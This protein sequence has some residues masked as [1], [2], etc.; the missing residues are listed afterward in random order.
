MSA[1]STRPRLSGYLRRFCEV[2]LPPNEDAEN[3]PEELTRKAEFVKGKEKAL[4]SLHAVK[5]LIVSKSFE[6]EDYVKNLFHELGI[7]AKTIVGSESSTEVIDETSVFLLRLFSKC[8]IIGT[9]QNQKLREAFGTFPYSSAREAFTVVKKIIES[10]NDDV[11]DEIIDN[12]FEKKDD[13]LLNREFGADIKFCDIKPLELQELNLIPFG[14]YSENVGKPLKNL[15]FKFE[16]KE[17]KLDVPKVE[18]MKYDQQWLETQI[19]KSSSNSSSSAASPSDL[20]ETI[21]M[22]LQSPSTNEELQ[23][24]LFDLLGFDRYEFIQDILRHRSDLLSSKAAVYSE[25]KLNKPLPSETRPGFLPQVTIQSELEKQLTKQ[26][27]KDEKRIARD[28]GKGTEGSSLDPAYLKKMREA[29]LREAKSTPLLPRSTNV[30]PQF[31]RYPNVYDIYAETQMSAAF[32][33]GRKMVLPENHQRTDNFIFEE[34]SIPIKK[35]DVSSLKG[36]KKDLIPIS[37]L[38]KIGQ[39]AFPKTTHLNLIQSMVFD[40]AYHTNENMLVCAP[41]GAGK[42]NVAMLTIIREIKNNIEI[43]VVKK[44]KFKIVYVAPMKALASEVVSNFSRRLSPLGIQVRELTGDTQLTKN[45]ILNTQML[46]TTPEK[47]DVVTRKATGDIALTQLVKLL[48]L[49]EVHLL[50]SDRGPVLEAL[51]ARTLRQVETS[52]SMIRILGLSATLPNYVEV[53]RFLRVNPAIGLFFFDDRFRPVPLSPT[54]IG[55]KNLNPLE[56]IKDMD[57]ICYQKVASLVKNNHQV[58]VF[59]H[60]RN[61]TVRTSIVLRDIARVKNEL[62][63][64]EACNNPTALGVA[65]KRIGGSRNKELKELFDY[66]FS[67]HHAG[68]LR[69][70]R[71]LVEK[72]FRDGLIKVLVCTS[73]LA[74]GVNLPARAV[75]IKGTEI[76]DSKHGNFVDLG[77]LD[78]M[79]IFGRAGRPQFDSEGQGTIITSHSRLYHYVSLLT[80]QHQ[81]ESNFPNSLADNLNAEVALGTVTSIE[82][83]VEWLSYTYFYV[84]AVSNPHAY[85]LKPQML[86]DDENL[87]KYRTQL[88]VGAADRLCRAKMINY[89]R[90]NGYLSS[91]DLGRIASHYYINAE[92][93]DRF[94]EGLK[95]VNIN[96]CAIFNLISTAQEFDQIKVRDDELNELDHLLH[97]CSLIVHC[98]CENKEGKVNIL[99]QMYLSKISIE[100]FSLISDQA[101]VVQNATR[102]ARALFEISLHKHWAMSTAVF[103]RVSK[104]LERQQWDYQTPLRQFSDIGINTLNRIEDAKPK[105][106]IEEMRELDMESLAI[107]GRCYNDR[108][109]V[110][111]CTDAIPN[112]DVEPIVQP[113]TTQILRLKL[114]ITP[115]FRWVDKIHGLGSETFWIWVEDPDTDYIYHFEY[116]LLQRKQVIKKELQTL[117]FT[118]PLSRE[119][120]PNQYIIRVVSDRWLGSDR[121]FPVSFKDMILPHHHLPQTDLLDLQ[122]LPVVAL[123]DHQFQLIY[124]FP[125]FN[126]IQTQ[127]FHTAYHTD[128]NMLVGAPTGSGKTI[129]AEIAM[130]RV[131]RTYPGTKVVYIAPLKALVRERIKDWR[132]RLEQRLG[133]SVVELTGDV[134]PDAKAVAA[135]DVIVTTPEKWDGIS[136]SWQTRNYVKSVSLIVIDEIHLLGEDRGPVLEVIVSRT[137]FI[138]AHTQKTLRIIGLSTA[139][140]NAADLANWLGIKEVGMYNFK[141]SVRPVPLEVH[142]S[143]Y[144]GKHYCPRMALMNKPT[145]QAIRT[146]S[147]DKPALV[148]V[149]SRRQTRLTALDLIAYLAAEE[150]PRQWIHMSVSEA[151]K[152]TGFLRDQNLKLTIAFGIGLHHA[153]LHESDRTIVEQLF[154]D[155]KIQVLIATAT[156]AWGVNLPAHLVVIKGTEY[157]DGKVQ[158]Y[159]DF[160]ITDVLQMMGRAGR[161]QFDDTGVAVVLVQDVKKNFYRKFLYEPF[162]VESSL[163]Q[164]LPDHLNAEIVA[165]TVST[166]QQCIEYLTWTYFFRRLLQN[167]MY[168]GLESIDHLEVNQYLSSLVDRS[169]NLLRNANCLEIEADNRGIK[170]TVLGRIASYYYLNY[171]TMQIFKEKLKDGISLYDYLK[172]LCETHEYEELPVRHNEDVMNCDLA[173]SCRFQIE[174]RNYESPHTKANLLFQAHFSRL[175]LPCTDYYTDL[176]SVLDQAIRI[177]QAMIDVASDNGSLSCALSSMALLQMV[178]Q[179]RWYDDNH[180]LTLPYIKQQHLPLFR[181]SSVSLVDASPKPIETLPDLIEAV[182]SRYELLASVLREDL[183]ENHID[184]IFKTITG[185]PVLSVNAAIRGRWDG[186]PKEETKPLKLQFRGGVRPQSY[187]TK[188]HADQEYILNVDLS[189]ESKLRRDTKAFAPKFPKLKDEGWFL[190][191]GDTEKNELLAMKRVGYVPRRSSH[192]VIFFTPE[193]TG[194]VCYALY[195]I[196]DC[197]LGL[198]QQYEVCLDVVEKTDFY[199][200]NEELYESDEESVYNDA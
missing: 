54:F 46:V 70:D 184:E 97:L 83:G 130:I 13:S 199:D 38:D 200:S 37:S 84:R 194:R 168:Y 100:S 40:T 190:V 53:A 4:T 77:V 185:L 20:A 140:A 88:I 175:Q 151:E 63:I 6:T 143:G 32:I 122:P 64:F 129:V 124:N 99:L 5:K 183:D 147:P 105:L 114:N 15:S 8:N 59:V 119:V 98:G 90:K 45:E 25:L 12:N 153:G 103:L 128:S 166:K 131:F 186:L 160:P 171:N 173:K 170:A 24:D 41:T 144:H 44:D 139:L 115:D 187:W 17:K 150:D 65:Q 78:V 62:S 102:I 28:M 198:D 79:Q 191:L 110:K 164:V 52:Q 154:L 39:A 61:A 174:E 51:V 179:G 81:I 1:I 30:L 145:Y 109:N 157:F 196:S 29:Q 158:R 146:H 178:L 107:R 133:K 76:Y 93:V 16:K 137:N 169:L 86:K 163:L 23:N 73:T 197:Y 2:S 176:K 101:Y 120:N 136:R 42:T 55:V 74:W 116:F 18:I 19:Q 9:K 91:T 159:V 60:A 69:Q 68:M 58:M 72:Y 14:T 152:V 47:W 135:A 27:R 188:V 148:F 11:R 36:I 192:Q 26:L 87:Q 85:G 43:D 127:I 118:I 161:P 34:I 117:V 141:P 50:D 142:L 94:D 96:E 48:I 113:I 66:G 172:V 189:R 123:H 104:M 111:F 132:I 121:S 95:S 155:Q 3:D 181:F 49:D 193:T 112:I 67:I 165:G 106:T 134:T 126:P 80:R 56:Q 162:P 22:F 125:Y 75:I 7:H 92:T 57:Q 182:S 35:S 71:N 156:L 33:S 10:L 89:D 149:S 21:I 31:T 108:K 195:V 180:L 138:S 82:E 177:I 167:P